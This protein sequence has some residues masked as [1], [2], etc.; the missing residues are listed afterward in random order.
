M[1][2]RIQ[3]EAP[4]PSRAYY[5]PA[6]SKDDD[7][8]Q[9][10]IQRIAKELLHVDADQITLNIDEFELPAHVPVKT[11]LRDEDLITYVC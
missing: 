6:L 7:T 3:A 2:V 9:A 8:I 1:R 5:Y 11:I 4:L 10:L